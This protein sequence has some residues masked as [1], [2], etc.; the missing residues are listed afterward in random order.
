M[1][2]DGEA[3]TSDVD[4]YS[5]ELNTVVAFC[6]F[7]SS[8]TMADKGQGNSPGKDQKGKSGPPDNKETNPPKSEEQPPVQPEGQLWTGLAYQRPLQPGLPRNV[9][10]LPGRHPGDRQPRRNDQSPNR[11]ADRELSRGRANVR[12][13]TATAEQP[14]LQEH[15][16]S[17]DGGEGGSK[18]TL[19]DTEGAKGTTDQPKGSS[20]EEPKKDGEKNPKEDRK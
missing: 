20:K 17:E 2:L 4:M 15:R 16:N 11:R 8:V 10:G 13:L 1:A 12:M 3:I 6:S 18:R 5:T 7:H 19:T 9:L 14:D